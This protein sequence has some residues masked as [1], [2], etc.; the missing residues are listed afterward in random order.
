MELK[1]LMEDEVLNIIDRVLENRDDICKCDKCKLD[2][3]AI[4]LNRL[5]PKYVVSNKGSLYAK[6]E[7]LNYQYE[8]NILI[9]ITR[10]MNIVGENPHHDQ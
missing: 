7:T 5:K 6:A 9:E 4:A 1:N 10:A 2:I 8:A 3:A